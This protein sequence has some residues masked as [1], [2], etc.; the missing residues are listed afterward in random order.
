VAEKIVDDGAGHIFCA[1][2]SSLD[3]AFTVMVP[4]ESLDV[5]P[6]SKKARFTVLFKRGNAPLGL[7]LLQCRSGHG[8]Y[9][10][11]FTT[12]NVPATLAIGDVMCMIEDRDVSQMTLGEVLGIIEVA[13]KRDRLRELMKD[14]IG[15]KGDRKR[16]DVSFV[17]E[18]LFP[19]YSL[20]DVALDPRKASF[21]QSFLQEQGRKGWGG[22]P[23]TGMGKT[24]A[25]AQAYETK[26]SFW[27]SGFELLRR[28]ESASLTGMTEE[29]EAEE[30][31]V[32]MQSLPSH[33]MECI[34]D[35][36]GLDAAVHAVG[37]ELEQEVMEDFRVSAWFGRMVAYLRGSP[38]FLYISF[39]DVS[40]DWLLCQA[41]MMHL[42]QCQRQG[43]LHAWNAVKTLQRLRT[44]PELQMNLDS[45]AARLQVLDVATFLWDCYLAPGSPFHLDV[46]LECGGA[47]STLQM[48][49][50]LSAS[51]SSDEQALSAI[52][53]E[54]GVTA[55]AQ[56]CSVVQRVLARHLAGPEMRSFCESVLYER[57]SGEVLGGILQELAV[58]ENAE[59]G[60]TAALSAFKQLWPNVDKDS[61]LVKLMRAFT[62]PAYLSKHRPP[63]SHQFARTSPS[64]RTHRETLLKAHLSLP[65]SQRSHG[66]RLTLRSSTSPRE[67]LVSASPDW[68]IQF[69]GEAKDGAVSVWVS[70]C[71]PLTDA[72]RS[73][74]LQGGAPAN[75]DPFLSPELPSGGKGGP[76]FADAP[77][78]PKL[79]NFV[80]PLSDGAS[81]LGSCLLLHRPYAGNLDTDDENVAQSETCSSARDLLVAAAADTHYF[82]T[83]EDSDE[84][85]SSGTCGESSSS[86]SVR[87]N[88][89]AAAAAAVLRRRS[90]ATPYRG[91]SDEKQIQG[92]E[93]SSF[94]G[95][96]AS[97]MSSSSSGEGSKEHSIYFDSAN[98]SVSLPPN[99]A[100]SSPQYL[101]CGVCLLTDTTEL[102]C[103]ETETG[104]VLSV[105]PESLQAILS[106]Y[107][108]AFKE[109]MLRSEYAAG[110]IGK[111]MH[112]WSEMDAAEL[113]M[114]IMPFCELAAT[115][116]NPEEFVASK[117]V[118]VL[119]ALGPRTM[120]LVLTALLCE[121]KVIMVSKHL[122][123]LTMMGSVLLRLLRPLSWSHVYLP[124][125]PL[126]IARDLLQCPTPFLLG[127]PASYLQEADPF[128]IPGDAAFVHL[129]SGEFRDSA[130]L[131]LGPLRGAFSALLG[132]LV[133]GL[134]HLDDPHVGPQPRPDGAREEY[135]FR[136]CH[137]V[138]N[139]AN[140]A[141]S[142]LLAG[143]PECCVSV[144]RGKELAVFF[145]ENAFSE[146]KSAQ[147]LLS[148]FAGGEVAATTTAEIFLH[149]FTKSQMFSSYII[150]STSQFLGGEI[151][152][153]LA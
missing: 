80:T 65:A 31:E 135:D 111:F 36:G 38:P 107:F 66:R 64:Q 15:S 132:V 20:R 2:G 126:R 138:I 9:I 67:R 41:F 119:K 77:Q 19:S 121:K 96:G 129:D 104:N 46:A 97:S 42:L 152:V 74:V 70:Q 151:D 89:I 6:L 92:D 53:S 12:T 133:P 146:M 131:G 39:A 114:E 105:E 76:C 78:P 137:Q 24:A 63:L 153:Y 59:P 149:L 144:G 134:R 108:L 150:E 106:S 68:L 60:G 128:P 116:G 52:S 4:R 79:F 93:Y 16:E 69:E 40:Q 94:A 147:G 81:M 27:L 3:R 140:A 55:I 54:Q 5:L 84:G 75:M 25:H 35:A 34:A 43:W 29:E 101:P 10:N 30:R 127:I 48:L 8:V 44:G 139:I 113:K 51:E 87:S 50:L 47:F 86:P 88:G 117:V 120:C 62:L 141:I 1:R 72:A 7:K 73:R 100:S 23:G 122:S 124:L 14:G 123:L 103:E 125:A 110:Q 130:P 13:R 112:H 143:T 83:D 56:A 145:D 37:Q 33:L 98:P 136:L 99:S 58:K 95:E 11:G 57:I 118:T 17:F 61:L 82:S 26:L 148:S 45:E 102:S 109:N 22:V 21:L 49:S 32:L 115:E 28:V 142:E 85:E 91:A 71:I 18:R 90:I